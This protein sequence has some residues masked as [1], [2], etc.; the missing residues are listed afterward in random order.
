MRSSSSTSSALIRSDWVAEPRADINAR[1]RAAETLTV[2]AFFASRSRRGVVFF[3]DLETP[4]D[5]YDVLIGLS[6]H[7]CRRTY[8][9][10]HA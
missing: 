3:R 2:I 5:E 4:D 9:V 8:T 6:Y 7:A 10:E 1:S